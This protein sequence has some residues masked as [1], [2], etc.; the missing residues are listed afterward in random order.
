LQM[1]DRTAATIRRFTDGGRT[2]SLSRAQF[3]LAAYSIRDYASA[4]VSKKLVTPTR[5]PGHAQL[6]SFGLQ[7][8]TDLKIAAA[9]NSFGCVNGVF[10]WT[11]WANLLDCTAVA[12]AAFNSGA[13]A[14]A[15]AGGNAG[16]LTGGVIGG[17]VGIPG[18]PAGVGGGFV[19]GSTLG[20][21]VGALIGGVG[22]GSYFAYKATQLNAACQDGFDGLSGN[23][24]TKTPDNMAWPDV[25]VNA[26]GPCGGSTGSSSSSPACC[27][28]TCVQSACLPGDQASN[29]GAA[30]SGDDGG[31]GAPS[32]MASAVADSDG[33]TNANAGDMPTDDQIAKASSNASCPS[34]P[35]GA[36]ELKPN[37]ANGDVNAT[38][39][40]GGSVNGSD[41]GDPPA[42]TMGA[43]GTTTARCGQPGDACDDANGCCS[44]P[45]N[46]GTCTSS[47]GTGGAAPCA[48]DTDCNTGETCNGGTCQT[49]NSPGTGG[50]Q[51]TQDSD[52]NTGET[53]NGG[54]CQTSSSPSSSGSAQC[55]QDTDCNTGETCNGGTCESSASPGSS[56][57]SC[58]GDGESCGS[59]GDCCNGEACCNGACSNGGSAGATC[60]QD[61][62]CCDG[63]CDTNAGTCN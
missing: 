37:G 54:T 16:W 56:G 34:C 33:G 27:S 53:C 58:A 14:G 11:T 48:Q 10:N 18:G 21:P 40:P 28:G 63:S 45:C 46:S 22:L 9:L 6:H 17:V 39:A 42:D 60:G 52:C 7:L 31:T 41:A 43:T 51:C 8:A 13:T 5:T 26:G 44:G 15:A 29:A 24:P 30:A 4:V 57:T 55:T 3:E 62:D 19:A 59:D 2:G 49:S 61:S 20:R 1:L 50:A 38:D 47:N 32:D 35:P 23:C 36:S 12:G 25:C